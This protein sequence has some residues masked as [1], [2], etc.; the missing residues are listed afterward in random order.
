VFFEIFELLQVYAEK[1]GNGAR[2]DEIS[3]LAESLSSLSTEELPDVLAN[4]SRLSFG[5]SVDED[6]NKRTLHVTALR[7][8]IINNYFFLQVGAPGIPITEKEL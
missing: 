6:G 1:I 5:E 2:T 4:F 8:F 3:G 7:R